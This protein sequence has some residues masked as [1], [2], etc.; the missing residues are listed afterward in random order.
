MQDIQNIPIYLQASVKMAYLALLED[1]AT[2]AFRRERIFR[3]QHNMF[4]ESDE[5]LISCFQ[6]P[7][8]VLLQLCNSLEW[9]LSHETHLSSNTFSGSSAVKHQFPGYQ[10]ISERNSRSGW[11]FTTFSKSYHPKGLEWHHKSNA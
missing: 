5:W 8:Q 3:D 6:L 2:H 7:R 1:F 4:E 9:N 11:H 10:E